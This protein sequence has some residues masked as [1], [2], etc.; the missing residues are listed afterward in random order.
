MARKTKYERT[1]NRQSWSKVSMAG[2]IQEVLSGRM[3]YKKASASFNVPQ[4]T[5]EDSKKGQAE[6]F[7]CGGR[8]K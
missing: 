3:G 5:L 6:W 2:A 7:V 1:T 4:T 8:C